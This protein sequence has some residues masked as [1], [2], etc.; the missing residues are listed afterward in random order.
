LGVESCCGCAGCI[1]GSGNAWISS[2][3]CS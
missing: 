1:C 3:G 2:L